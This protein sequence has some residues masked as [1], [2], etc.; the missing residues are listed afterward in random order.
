M[1]TRSKN[2]V[3]TLGTFDLPHY[4]HYRHLKHAE[5]IGEVTVGLN[6][7]EFVTRYKGKPPIMTYEER[8]AT[9]NEWGYD[10]VKN[11]QSDGNIVD[12]IRETNANVIAIGTDWA[13]KD[14][15]AQIGLNVDYLEAND[16]WLVYIP[17]TKGISTTDIKARF[18]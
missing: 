1:L 5:M 9:I 13:R 10:V 7:D 12:V 3:L 2:L 17:Y 8:E 15:L 4:G 6:S 14:Y 18:K 11:D 16:I